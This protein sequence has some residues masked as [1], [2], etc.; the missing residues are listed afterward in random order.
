VNSI[1]SI[2][3]FE[4]ISFNGSRREHRICNERSQGNLD[5]TD[6][7]GQGRAY[8]ALFILFFCGLSYHLEGE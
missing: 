2:A 5:K 8:D 1:V 3:A 4:L 7:L 6:V